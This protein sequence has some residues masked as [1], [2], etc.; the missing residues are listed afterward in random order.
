MLRN[1]IY[2]H[3]QFDIGIQQHENSTIYER[4]SCKDATQS[5]KSEKL[6]VGVEA[7]QTQ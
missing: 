4:S 6:E 1:L 5:I 3:F 2:A 7:L